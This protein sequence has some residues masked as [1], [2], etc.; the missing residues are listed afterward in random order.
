MAHWTLDDIPWHVFDASR[1]EPHVIP[2]IKAACMVEHNG[3]DYA[4]YLN[5]VFHDDPEFQQASNDWAVEEVQH[6]QALRKWA[7]LADPTFN[8]DESF[9][10]FTDGY[11]LP[12][13]VEASVRG[14]RSGELIARCVVESGTSSY[15]TAIKNWTNEPVLQLVCAKIAGDEFRH[16][17]LF[18]EHLKRYLAKEHIGT[19]KRIRIALGRVAES[20]DD[21]LA[22]AYYAANMPPSVAYDHERFK[23]AYMTAAYSF[24]QKPDVDKVTAMVLKAAGFRPGERTQKVINFVAWKAM[25]YQASKAA[26]AA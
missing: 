16:Y 1:A 26:K 14:S 4:R 17:K 13:N 2:V 6:G 18:Y 19:F 10:R 7:E 5:E 21:E 22:Y 8:F 11:K 20:E 9:K 12:L 15:Y 3:Y 25:R 23:N 24:Y